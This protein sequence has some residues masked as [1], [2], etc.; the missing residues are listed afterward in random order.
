MIKHYSLYMIL[1]PLFF[2]SLDKAHAHDRLTSQITQPIH[3]ALERGRGITA[4]SGVREIETQ[5]FGDSYR[6]FDSKRNIRVLD[7][8]QDFTDSDNIWTEEAATGVEALWAFQTSYDYFKNTFNLKGIDNNNLLLNVYIDEENSAYGAS[9]AGAFDG[10]S[11]NFTSD[12]ASGL[13][14][15][16]A[17]DI[18]A[19]EYTHGVSR[20]SAD[21]LLR[22][23]PAILD[24]GFADIF[25]AVVKSQVAPEKNT[26]FFGKEPND[27]STNKSIS[28][29]VRYMKNPKIGNQPTTY[30]GDN[31][32]AGQ[33]HEDANLLGH[34]FY[35]LSE[36][37]VGINDN[38]DHFHVHGIG[39]TQAARITYRMLTTHLKSTAT[40]MATREAGIIAATDLYGPNS[41]VV[42]QVTNAFFAIGIGEALPN[43]ENMEY[44]VSIQSADIN[45][46]YATLQWHALK[47]ASGY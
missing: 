1:T 4:Y 17:L 40:F 42:E 30:Q 36:G 20:F 24:E 47:G 14:P 11:I 2:Y 39:I 31:W 35:I 33:L 34:W 13:A 29:L 38:N 10:S 44:P 41:H 32:S 21:F 23:E 37:K 19:H 16:T 46:T 7:V 26:W 43:Q 28:S 9:Y 27:L 15:L 5:R 22:G 18:V 12:R 6:L 8:N 3:Q 25:A 45:N